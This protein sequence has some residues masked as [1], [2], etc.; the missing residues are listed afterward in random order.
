MSQGFV[1]AG[2]YSTSRA[3]LRVSGVGQRR[4]HH[5]VLAGP[6]R[7][8]VKSCWD[9]L[10]YLP[11]PGKTRTE[12]VR[13]HWLATW[14]K[15]AATTQQNLITCSRS[16][17]IFFARILFPQ[18]P[19]IGVPSRAILVARSQSDAYA[20]LKQ[21]WHWYDKRFTPWHAIWRENSWQCAWGCGCGENFE[22][23]E[24]FFQGVTTC[25]DDIVAPFSCH[26]VNYE[27]TRRT[28]ACRNVNILKFS[29][30]L[31]PHYPHLHAPPRLLA[32]FLPPLVHQI[33]CHGVN[34]LTC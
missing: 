10:R 12:P 14:N 33:A 2:S 31:G 34:R 17:D 26:F 27:Q 11:Q 29:P 16:E 8:S 23:F 5:L 24:K 22:M 30:R 3:V 21:A 32:R 7:T 1:E 18:C 15:I 19:E 28:S 25:H 9:G 20:T 6:L 4:Q 13:A